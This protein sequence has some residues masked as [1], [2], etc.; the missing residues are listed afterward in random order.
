MTNSKNIEFL[1]LQ[2]YSNGRL[3]YWISE[4]LIKP[5]SECK[6]ELFAG[7]SK[8]NKVVSLLIQPFEYKTSKKSQKYFLL[9]IVNI[10]K[11]LLDLKSYTDR[12]HYIVDSSKKLLNLNSFGQEFILRLNKKDYS[13]DNFNYINDLFPELISYGY[14]SFKGKEDIYDKTS[15]NSIVG[16][17]NL[18]LNNIN[19]NLLNNNSDL[20][21]FNILELEEAFP[22]TFKKTTNPT[23]VYTDYEPEFYSG[24][25]K[26]T[27]LQGLKNYTNKDSKNNEIKLYDIQLSIIV[28]QDKS[29]TEKYLISTEKNI[30][31]KQIRIVQNMDEINLRLNNNEQ[32]KVID[33]WKTVDKPFESLFKVTEEH[34][35]LIE[36]YK[37]YLSTKFNQMGKYNF[38]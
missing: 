19:E 4:Q 38:I 35:V 11:D 8:N 6:P 25:C 17:V 24:R 37:K 29:I 31:F 16:D 23:K 34:D 2:N 21:N 28:K 33:M 10:E 30:P 36:Y 18:N 15:S 1:F 12:A 27:Q 32:L 20:V 5:P 9:L 13:M 14:H 3:L 26:I 22:I 7:R